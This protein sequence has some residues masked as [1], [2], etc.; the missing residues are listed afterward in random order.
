MD[1]S[2]RLALSYYQT[3][4]TINEEHNIYLVQHR[5][6]KKIFVKKILSVYNI[7]IFRALSAHPVC[8]IPKIIEYCE[9]DNQLT[10]IE[11]YI[12]GQS[13]Y[14]IVHASA[15][16]LPTVI[17]YSV[18]L[19]DILCRLHGMQ[20]P[21]VHRDIKP[22]NI[23]ITEHNHVVLIDYNAAKFYND[24][25]NND[26]VLLGTQGYAAPEQYGF[27]SSSPKTDIYAMG[28]LLKELTA[29]LP[30]IPRSLQKII[31][32]CVRMNPSER[33][34]TVSDLRN[35]LNRIPHALPDESS[36][37][38]PYTR[39]L[40]P[41]FRTLTVWKMLV[42]IPSYA[43]IFWLALTIDVENTYGAAL[44]FERI[45]LLIIFLSIVFFSCNY[46]NVHRFLP[47]CNSPK[48]S[49]RILGIVLFDI[50][51]VI[52]MLVMMVIIMSVLFGI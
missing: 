19:C 7:D 14:D 26:T 51:L 39:F 37:N 30:N 17:H 52:A 41:G 24:S 40:L 45:F 49:T 5:E 10:I 11:N 16:E 18:E 6:T 42:A 23:I 9:S 20:P 46:L 1:Y 8:G 29:S 15:L 36:N 22:S 27:G 47:L 32:R 43:F 44:W 50:I 2:N 38:H 28:I 35:A 12:S 33:Y 13:L 21:I 25:S 3:V 48:R 34:N 31:D 4:A